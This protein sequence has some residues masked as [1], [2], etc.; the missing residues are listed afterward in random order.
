[1]P[2]FVTA[3]LCRIWLKFISHAL[4]S[5]EDPDVEHIPEVFSISEPFLKLYLRLYLFQFTKIQFRFVFR[6][7]FPVGTPVWV[8][9]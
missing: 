8:N 9:V 6:T 1:M 4:L 3:L 2:G 5:S 7:S